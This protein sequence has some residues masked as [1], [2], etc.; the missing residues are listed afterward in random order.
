LCISFGRSV[1]LLVKA[2]LSSWAD[3]EFRRKQHRLDKAR[4]C[5]RMSKERPVNAKENKACKISFFVALS[6]I[7]LTIFTYK[8]YSF[9]EKMRNLLPQNKNKTQ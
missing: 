9:K 7:F 6:T 5:T 8:M 3:A 1:S 4:N 2:A